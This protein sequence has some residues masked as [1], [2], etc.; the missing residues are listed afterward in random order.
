MAVP[1]LDLKAQ[2]TTI[3]DAIEVALHRVFEN[4]RF[5]LGDEVASFEA[6]IARLSGVGHGVGVSSGSDALYLALRALG[7]GPGD[8]VVTTAYSFFATAGAIVRCGATPVFVDIDPRTFNIDPAAA[9]ARVNAKTRA[10]LPVHLFG[11]CAAVDRL[12]EANLPIIEDAAQA[13][14][15]R[16]KGIAAGALGTL[17]CFSFFPSKNL[18]GAGDG[19][20]V[21]TS[22]DGLAARLRSLRVHGQRPEA[23]YEHIEVGG[24][25]RLDALQA[26]ILSVKLDHLARWN[27]ARQ[28]HAAAYRRLFVEAGVA[29]RLTLP[30]K[31]DEGATDVYNQFVIRLPDRDALRAHLNAH[32]IGNAIYYPR[33]LHLQPCFADLGGTRG[34]FPIAEEA[35]AQ[36]LALPVFPELT[37]RQIQEVV[38]HIV[39]FLRLHPPMGATS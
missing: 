9:L 28:A 33:A 25:Y 10:L 37:D 7:V 32:A 19:G 13:I 8:E 17:G 1:F 11:R 4:Q 36:S 12:Q 3:R 27:A 15:A 23:R 20:L 30:P 29:T 26:A 38:G 18:G 14:G 6:A 21:T 24:N 5:I 35:A 22:D 34:D 39:D 16:Y 31:A 2:Y